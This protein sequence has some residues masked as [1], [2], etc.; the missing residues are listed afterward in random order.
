[1][2]N[3]REL[4]ELEKLHEKIL[5]NRNNDVIS[6]EIKYQNRRFNDV[7]TFTAKINLTKNE[8][9]YAMTELNSAIKNKV[10]QIINESYFSE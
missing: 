3:E 8:G 1:M 7:F 2:V 9:Y 10:N 5:Q 6:I 4:K